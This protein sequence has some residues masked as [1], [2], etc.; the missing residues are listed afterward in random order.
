VRRETGKHFKESHHESEYIP[1]L[2]DPD[3]SNDTERIATVDSLTAG[4]IW[5][6]PSLWMLGYPDRA[7]R[8]HQATEVHTRAPGH[9]LSLCWFLTVGTWLFLLR[10]EP[11][12][13]VMRTEEGVQL[14]RAQGVPVF[15]AV[16]A[17]MFRGAVWL[18][19]GRNQNGVAE[20]RDALGKWTAVGGR[21]ALPYFNALVA[22]GLARIGDSRARERGGAR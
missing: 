5:G 7:L 16:L 10:E 9:P 8:L 19:M 21:V 12:Q 1:V 18:H 13:V 14:A 4:G 17:P 20:L 22:A 11:E 6:S 2:Y 3:R 15:S